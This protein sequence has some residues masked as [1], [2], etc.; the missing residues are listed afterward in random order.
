MKANRPFSK[1]SD[2]ML[3]IM[4]NEYDSLEHIACL[5]ARDIFSVKKRIIELFESGRALEIHKE[6]K[7]ANGLYASRVS[8][9]PVCRFTEDEGED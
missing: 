9:L 6:L 7:Q 1:D 2:M 4:H 3:I 8:D 5:F